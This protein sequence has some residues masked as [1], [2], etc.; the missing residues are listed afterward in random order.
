MDR[1]R[2]DKNGL[3]KMMDEKRVDENGGLKN[4]L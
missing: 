2:V 1:K 3:K 4:I